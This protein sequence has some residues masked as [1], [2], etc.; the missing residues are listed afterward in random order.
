MV[1]PFLKQIAEH[2][3]ETAE[4]ISRLV[5]VFPSIRAQV[6]FKKWFAQAVASHSKVPVRMPALYTIDR[7]FDKFA[8]GNC[9]DNLT[10]VLLLYDCYSGICREKGLK[11]ETLDEFV[12]WGDVILNDFSDIDRYMINADDLLRNVSDLKNL[13][14]DYSYLSK[15]Q[16]EA[17][18]AFLGHFQKEG[19]Y[20]LRFAKL[21]NILSRLY[22]DFNSVLDEKGLMY[23]AKAVRSV[24]ERFAGEG[25]ADVF[26]QAFPDVDKVVF[27][28]LNVLCESE[29]KILAR[30]RDL[31]LADFCWDYSS[32]WIRNR[33][34]KSSLFMD[35][36]LAMFP[37]AFT[38]EECPQN[39][40]FQVIEVP[41]AIGQAKVVSD[42]L[43]SALI[44]ADETTAIILPD[45][46]LLQPLLNSIPERVGQVNVTMGCGMA[47]S[48][49]Y[50]LMN[51]ISQMQMRLR[52]K[53]GKYYFYHRPFW[54]VAGSN[55]FNALM[56]EE[57]RDILARLKK[58]LKYYICQDDVQGSEFLSKIFRPVI[59]DMKA[60]DKAKLKDIQDYQLEILYY[61]G[62][63]L[64]SDENLKTVYSLELDFAMEYIKAVNLVSSHDMEIL[65][66]TYFAMLD[67]VLRS[68]SIPIKG[69]PLY[70]LQI[71]GPLETRALDFDHVF[72][73]SCNEGVFPRGEAG[74]SFIPPL[75]RAAF[76]LPTYEYQDAVW[77]YYFYRLIQRASS[78]VM[79]MDSRSE[80]MRSGEESRYIKQLQY[81][82]HVPIVRK[83]ATAAPQSVQQ[84]D[85]VC[86]TAEDIAFIR[87]KALSP[88][89]L[90]NYLSCSMKFYYSFVK[91]L[92][93]DDEVNETMDAGIVGDIYHK[94]MERLYDGRPQN[95]VTR[96]YLCS[97]KGDA[98]AIR[99]MVYA[100]AMKKMNTDSITGR[101][102]VICA[103]ITKYVRK[104]IERDIEFMD[105]DKVDWFTVLKLEKTYYGKLCGLEFKGTVDRLDSFRDGIVRLV[106]YKTG[107][108]TRDDVEIDDSNAET[109]A[110]RI[111]DPSNKS[112]EWPKIALQFYIYDMLIRQKHDCDGALLANSVYST[113]KIMSERPVVTYCNESFC[114]HMEQKLQACVDEILSPD[115]PFTRHEPGY[116]DQ[117]CAYCDFKSICGR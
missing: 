106:D 95:R 71:M 88:T 31:S 51:D 85:T 108:V 35:A 75:L 9:A 26:T 19:E 60:T 17:I 11:C 98:D 96:E 3:L 94:V 39:A 42:L 67:N 45:E 15:N 79:T 37:P 72:I 113:R 115:I 54:N 61:I 69:E 44:P 100:Q 53:D 103:I 91:G 56:D 77:A 114:R 28:G 41:S 66:Q 50:T 104:T 48:S 29:K 38:M 117:T 6:F 90:Q 102:I 8:T 97:L 57:S 52:L 62:E 80:G 18:K 10:L 65:P 78:V 70:G 13:S 21:W 55:L 16:E 112:K 23:A 34:N 109:I 24:A 47:S 22:H 32:D 105:A 93:A 7:F 36:N 14:D 87:S 73:L 81:H 82:F 25:A 4:D 43:E 107:K 2:Y 49:F 30:L 63:R 116:G 40:S 83:S 64:S 74:S 1:T 111:F 110:A 27:C 101:N 59:K 5:F 20:K 58:D 89:A 76:S 68:K 12:F 92:R 86:K 33:Q 99:D 84:Q 46:N